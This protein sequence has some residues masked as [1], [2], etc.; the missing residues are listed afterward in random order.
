MSIKTIL[1]HLNNERRADVLLDVAAAIAAASGA[2]LIGTFAM[3][4][5][6]IYGGSPAEAQR[7]ADDKRKLEEM[8]E[9]LR[10]IFQA[11]L[12]DAAVAGEWLALQADES[13]AG[14]LVSRCRSADLVVA[15]QADPDFDWSSDIDIPQN[16]IMESGRPVLL[17]PYAGTFKTIGRRVVLAWNDSRESARAAF[18]AL[19][20]MT[21]DTEA[22]V[23]WFSPGQ[24]A[25]STAKAS[26]EAMAAT[27]ER[28]GIKANARQSFASDIAVGSEMLNHAADSG[29]DLLVM[30]CYG[31]SRLREMLLGGATREILGSMTIPVLMSH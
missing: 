25:S 22:D 24:T 19:P 18:D 10:G 16:L 13:G 9:R 1:V 15:S 28:H 14:A 7:I 17:I 8:R 29:A 3:P 11:K 31:H 21:A 5:L 23:V 30:G 6:R 20:L 26:T 2:R 4:P 27:L 12:A